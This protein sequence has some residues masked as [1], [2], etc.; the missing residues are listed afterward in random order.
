M[1]HTQTTLCA[2]HQAPIGNTEKLL[3]YALLSQAHPDNGHITLAWEECIH[4]A[5]GI[6]PKTLRNRLSALSAA[7]IL[8]YT[9]NEFVDITFEA[10]RREAAAGVHSRGDGNPVPPPRD[11]FPK[12]D[13]PATSE[14]RPDG[15][16]V[17]SPRENLPEI[18]P[19]PPRVSEYLPYT[20]EQKPT[21]S[22]PQPLTPAQERTRQ[23]LSQAGVIKAEALAR[24]WGFARCRDHL[25]QWTVDRFDNPNLKPGALEHRIR[26]W[27]P[28]A[29]STDPR[30]RTLREHWPTD[31][32]SAEQ[33]YYASLINRPLPI[34]AAEVEPPVLTVSPDPPPVAPIAAIPAAAE[35]TWS[36]VQRELELSLDPATFNAWLRPIRLVAWKT[37]PRGPSIHIEAPDQRT[38]D[39]LAFRLEPNIRRT[40]AH[41]GAP[42]VHIAFTC[43][44]PHGSAQKPIGD[45]A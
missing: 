19:T 16:P 17:P 42:G 26:K 34:D 24:A 1:N 4:L 5:D 31:E 13:A 20:P 32:E 29:P 15:N 22:A 14:S 8:H 23:M 39:F 33:E 21:H 36:A 38:R 18:P 7:G 28:P 45:P 27:S 2:I 12:P 11:S 40:F 25:L 3:A 6:A 44:E 10:W 37:T 35:K 30:V 43:P 41:C 9:T